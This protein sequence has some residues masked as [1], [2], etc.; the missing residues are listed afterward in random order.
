MEAVLRKQC[1]AKANQMAQGCCCEL[2]PDDR[3]LPHLEP[4][5]TVPIFNTA[6]NGVGGG[7]QPV[8]SS[9]TLWEVGAGDATGLGSVTN[10][11]PAVVTTEAGAWTD[12]GSDA[13]TPVVPDADWISVGQNSSQPGGY[14]YFR[15]RFVLCEG[16]DPSN[17]SLTASV[18]ADNHLD[19]IFVNGVA[20]GGDYS[21]VG[22]T[23]NP[24]PFILTDNWQ[25]CMNSVVFQVRNRPSSAG[26][27]T[28]MGFLAQI[29]LSGLPSL[30]VNEPCGTCECLPAD[31]PE[32]APTF[33]VTWGDGDCDC[34][35]TND[36]EVICITAC[37]CYNNVTFENLTLGP[38]TVVD[39]FGSP[40]PN[41]PD[42]TPSVE[43]IPYGPVCFG[44]LGPCGN[45]P[46]QGQGNCKS[47]QVAIRTRGA[48]A[49]KY[50]LSLGTICYRIAYTSTTEACFEFDLCKD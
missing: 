28:Q 15:L 27:P 33:C 26:S 6:T 4:G 20:Q 11:N 40:V 48:V 22:F 32:L 47:R 38:I 30:P 49:G 45:D 2:G 41:L 18:L 25:H 5:A 43:V 10:W 35:E 36:L 37:N 12:A 34:F 16:V 23:G 3:E 21:Q 17:F 50:Q 44:D 1:Q 31:L 19:G 46:T 29:A 13:G 7:T 9:D 42:G 14:Y 8:G 39:E 24:L